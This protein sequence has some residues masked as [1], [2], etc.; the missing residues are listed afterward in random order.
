MNDYEQHVYDMYLCLAMHA[1]YTRYGEQYQPKQIA[2]MADA[3]AK[4]LLAV[5]AQSRKERGSDE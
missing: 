2:K 4:E 1:I 5:R 3:Q